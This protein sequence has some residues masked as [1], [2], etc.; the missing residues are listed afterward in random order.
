[1]WCIGKIK[2]DKWGSKLLGKAIMTTAI[3]I[4]DIEPNDGIKYELLR[5][6]FWLEVL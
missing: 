6:Y 5:Y 4:F 1:M 2:Y 3:K